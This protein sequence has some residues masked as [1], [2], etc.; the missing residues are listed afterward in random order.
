[1][2]EYSTGYEGTPLHVILYLHHF[3]VCLGL[4][5]GCFLGGSAFKSL[6]P[7]VSFIVVRKYGSKPYRQIHY[8]SIPSNLITAD[9][10]SFFIIAQ[11]KYFS[12]LINLVNSWIMDL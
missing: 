11:E 5:S 6:F 3:Q 12:I 9:G 10:V 8:Q 7:I 4:G 2:Q 1:M